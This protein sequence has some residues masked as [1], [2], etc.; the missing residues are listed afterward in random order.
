MSHSAALTVRGLSHQFALTRVLDNIDLSLAQGETLALVGP[1]GCGK[2]TLLN[3]IAGLLQPSAGLIERHSEPFSLM[4][5]EP[6]LLPWKNTLQNLSLGLKAQ[7]LNAAACRQAATQMAARLGLSAEDLRKYP[8]E[9]SGGMQSRV[10]LGRALMINPQ[11]LLLDEPFSALDIGLK[12]EL[13]ALLRHYIAEQC[14]SV[15]MITHDLLEA[16]RLADRIL[17]M[18]P[19]PG[20]WLGEFALHTAHE[21]RTEAWVYQEMASLMQQ[22]IVRQAFALPTQENQC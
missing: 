12:I 4:F 6:R 9:L 17:I 1:S 5:Q 20:R 18:V 21:Q 10:A 14:S 16:V 7:G 2:S 19:A 3:C 22:P 13:Y 15:L 8:H 11:L